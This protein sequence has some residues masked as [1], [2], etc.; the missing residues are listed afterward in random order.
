MPNATVTPGTASATA[1][2]QAV[3]AVLFDWDCTLIDSGS[4]LLGAWHTA[5][6]AV[7]GRRFPATPAEEQIIFTLPGARIWPDLTDDPAEQEAL[8]AQFQQAYEQTSERIRSFAGVPE[9]LRALRGA[10]VATA[11]VTAKARRRFTTD[12]SRA[13]L[14]GLIDVSV[15]AEDAPAPKPDPRPLLKA[16][17]ELGVPPE[18]A[19]MVGDTF[20]DVQAGVR[21]GTGVIG[22]AWGASTE[23]QLREAGATTV[24]YEP[25]EL[26]SA[27]LEVT[28]T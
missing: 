22:V 28:Q 9:A 21:A 24:V 17:E 13:G 8:V 27:V 18:R 7:I 3:A 16:L 6:E 25:A 4:A 1:P 20:V 23:E 11:V 14:D 15:C 26:A 12:V 19:V 10:G 5:T 2:A